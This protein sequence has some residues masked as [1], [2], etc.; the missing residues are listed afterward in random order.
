M[1]ETQRNAIKEADAA[2][3]NSDLLATLR[4]RSIANKAKNEKELAQKYCMRQAELGVGDCGGLRFIPGATKNGKQKTPKWLQDL[5]GV[6][7]GEQPD[8]D[9]KF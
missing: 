1:Q 6:D 5:L 3:E 9:L 8:V 2:F 7:M 4:E